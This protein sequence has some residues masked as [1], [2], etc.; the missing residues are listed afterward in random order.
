MR[1]RV[2]ED[3]GK[4]DSKDNER[5]RPRLAIQPDG[6]ERYIDRDEHREARGE[7]AEKVVDR[8]RY[9]VHDNPL[10]LVAR[11]PSNARADAG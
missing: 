11:L 7:I 4:N 8:E 6:P 3:I 10:L 9:L 5:C 1:D 2:T